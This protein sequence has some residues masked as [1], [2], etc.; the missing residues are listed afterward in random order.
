MS[1][2]EMW[3]LEENAHVIKAERMLER[4]RAGEIRLTSNGWYDLV[5]LVTGDVEQ[6]ER[7]AKEYIRQ[8]LRA[9]RN[10]E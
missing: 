10:P 3:A 1:R 6:A 4:A 9:N 7:A 8:E 2:E 5:M